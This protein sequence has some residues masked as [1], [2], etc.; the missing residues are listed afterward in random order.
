MCETVGKK[1]ERSFTGSFS[2]RVKSKLHRQVATASLEKAVS[3][4]WVAV[5][6]LRKYVR[7]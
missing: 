6:A 7:Q 1:P 2:I 5:D 3:L 4:D